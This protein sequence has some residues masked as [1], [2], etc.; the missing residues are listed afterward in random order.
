MNPL[1]QVD[2]D[3]F[4]Q[5]QLLRRLL[6]RQ[7]GRWFSYWREIGTDLSWYFQLPL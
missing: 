4:F 7:F 5:L 2:G 3:R 6:T 1:L